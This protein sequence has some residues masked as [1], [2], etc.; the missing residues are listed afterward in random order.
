MES[1]SKLWEIY[2]NKTDDEPSLR[3]NQCS[4]FQKQPQHTTWKKKDWNHTGATWQGRFHWT[5]AVVGGSKTLAVFSG[6]SRTGVSVKKSALAQPCSNTDTPPKTLQT[7]T[8]VTPYV[9]TYFWSSVVFW[10]PKNV[11]QKY[12]NLES[13]SE[14]S[15]MNLQWGASTKAVYPATFTH[16]PTPS[17]PLTHAHTEP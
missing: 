16:L 15:S 8:P 5:W 4:P 11:T 14:S 13:Q 6:V 3:T 2:S 7:S 1:L 12:L 17:Y 10:K 9:C